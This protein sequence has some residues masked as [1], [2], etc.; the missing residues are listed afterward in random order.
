MHWFMHA[1]AL[2]PPPLPDEALDEID[3]EELDELPVVT[4][5]WR[6]VP[7]LPPL[8][9]APPEPN[10]PSVEWAQAALATTKGMTRM[11]T[12]HFMLRR[13]PPESVRVRCRLLTCSEDGESA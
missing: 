8:P 13:P 6:P 5:W 2:Q 4:P 10:A 12:S 1:C 7:L 9:P 11:P 3:E